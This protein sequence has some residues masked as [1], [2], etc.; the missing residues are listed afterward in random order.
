MPPWPTLPPM[1]R[2]P[3]LTSAAKHREAAPSPPPRHMFP[4][5]RKNPF[6]GCYPPCIKTFIESFGGRGGKEI[7]PPAVPLIGPQLPLQSPPVF[8]HVHYAAAQLA[9]AAVGSPA[10]VTGQWQGQ[11][12]GH[13]L[14]SKH[15]LQPAAALAV[16][17]RNYGK[18]MPWQAFNRCLHFISCRPL[19]SLPATQRRVSLKGSCPPPSHACNSFPPSP[20]AQPTSACSLSSTKCTP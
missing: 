2:R 9:P 1:P 10:S 16:Y 13:D 18:P 12:H 7:P 19:V 6:K 14:A 17:Q 3:L 11:F 5:Q 4:P 8:H 20:T 15:Q